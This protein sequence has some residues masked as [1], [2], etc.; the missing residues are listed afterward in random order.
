MLNSTVSRISTPVLFGIT[1]A[2]ASSGLSPCL[3]APRARVTPKRTGV[4][5]LEKVEFSIC[6]LVEN[7]KGMR[8]VATASLSLQ[9]ACGTAAEDYSARAAHPATNY[10][11]RTVWICTAV[12]PIGPWVAAIAVT[13]DTTTNH[14][15]EDR[16]EDRA[17]AR[18]AAAH[19]SIV[20][21][22]RTARIGYRNRLRTRRH[23]RR[24]VGD[25]RLSDRLLF[26]LAHTRRGPG[27]DDLRWRLRSGLVMSDSV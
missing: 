5:I 9:L 11:W 17:N 25:R 22:R 23:R 14:S 4:A 16:A 20:T 15:A 24:V 2:S 1:V 12:T 21:R 18:T 27:L 13:D 26:G 19:A 10:N 3:Q 7:E 8:P 6:C